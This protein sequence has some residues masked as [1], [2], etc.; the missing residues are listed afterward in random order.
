MSSSLTLY[1]QDGNPV[2]VTGDEMEV[3]GIESG[4][5]ANGS[6]TKFPDGTMTC[7]HSYTFPP[8]GDQRWDF[9]EPFTTPPSVTMG[10]SAQSSA[11]LV[12]FFWNSTTTS[13]QLV[14]DSNVDVHIELQAI[15]RWK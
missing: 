14:N 13:I 2:V 7:W 3:H 15:G 10:S 12:R 6:W 4:S 1:K 8:N 9:P 5:N 11:G